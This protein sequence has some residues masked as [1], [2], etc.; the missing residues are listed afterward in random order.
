MCT[1]DMVDHV[2]SRP[3]C[4]LCRTE[5]LVEFQLDGS[6]LNLA[7]SLYLML[8]SSYF[9]GFINSSLTRDPATRQWQIVNT[10]SN[11]LIAVMEGRDS[12]PLGTNRWYF[13]TN[14]TDPG[15]P[16]RQGSSL[17]RSRTVPLFYAIK[18]QL[19]HPKTQRVISCPTLILHG[20][21][22]PIFFPCTE[23]LI[24]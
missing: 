5:D 4:P 16:Y 9:L 3:F 7:D 17:H 6:C 10:F 20:I 14:C 1:E 8:N 12:F 24:T 21:R 13:L 19:G 2:C 15:S 18:N 23:I 11:S 22:A